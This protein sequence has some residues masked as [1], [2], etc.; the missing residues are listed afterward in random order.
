MNTKVCC[1]CKMELPINKFGKDSHIL[2]GIHP[3][4]KKCRSKYEKERWRSR[5]PEDRHAEYL[6]GKDKQL[7]QSRLKLYGLEKQ[8]YDNMR[9]E[10]EFKCA[11][12][13]RHETEFAKSLHVDH[14]HDTGKIRGLLCAR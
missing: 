13:G 11:I 7:A 4:C 5:T 3:S 8:D 10:Q 14:C 2:N 1:K 12:C 9:I 6:R